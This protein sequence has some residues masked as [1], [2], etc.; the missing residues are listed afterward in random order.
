MP[1]ERR[2]L[3]FPGETFSIIIVCYCVLALGCTYL[4]CI[5]PDQTDTKEVCKSPRRLTSQ[6][7]YYKIP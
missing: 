5:E 1:H 6:A 3:L 4:S 7:L 2:R